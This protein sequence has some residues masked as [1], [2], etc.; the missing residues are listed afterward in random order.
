MPAIYNLACDTC[1]VA[2][3][4]S[5]SMTMVELADGTREI[6]GHPLER[7]VAE[8]LT[9]ESWDQLVGEGRIV[10]RYTAVCA[11]CGVPDVYDAA[12]SARGHARSITREPSIAD[13]AAR[14]CTACGAAR[15]VPLAKAEA[16]REIECPHC[17]HGHLKS[18]ICGFS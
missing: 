16:I 5:P 14:S 3:K 11:V 1:E 4:R 18:E 15:L 2:L 7:R 8:R 13:L 12:G 9:G 17:A 6:C 10:Y